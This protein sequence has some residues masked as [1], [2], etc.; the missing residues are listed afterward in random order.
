MSKPYQVV[1]IGNAL[2]DVLAHVE[3]KFLD[4]NGVQKA[5]MQLIDANRAVEL[6]G[7]MGPAKEISGGS[8]AN[9][10]AGLAQIGARTAYVGKVKDDQLGDIFAHDMRALGAGYDTPRASGGE[11]ETG[12]CYV[13]VTPDGERSLNTYLGVSEH[14]GPSDLSLIHI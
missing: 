1:G 7:V 4:E 5:I 10:I 14:L 9:T 8:A 11:H 2:V 6:Y 3:E 12:R 13:L